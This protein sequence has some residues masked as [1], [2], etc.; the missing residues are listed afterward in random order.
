[1]A[2]EM[3]TRYRA[4][5]RHW[6]VFYAFDTATGNS[7]SLKTGDKKVAQRLVQAMN[8]AETEVAIRKQVGL[9]YLKAADPEAAIPLKIR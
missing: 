9:M 1:M 6:G 2:I 8:E 4:F 3:K 7:K 5:K